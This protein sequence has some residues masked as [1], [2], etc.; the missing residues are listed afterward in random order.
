MAPSLSVEYRS[1]MFALTAICGLIDAACFLALGGV[2]AEL[3]TG[4]LLLLAFSLGTQTF[5]AAN[6]VAYMGAILPFCLGAFSAGLLTNGKHPLRA[7]M[8][9]Y[10]V[11]FIAVLAAT[12]LTVVLD[13]VP[14]GPLGVEPP[15]G[16]DSPAWQRLL[17]VA[18]LAFA[19]GIHNA[20]MRKHGMPDV[21]TNVMTL[22]LAGFVSESKLSRGTA[23]RWQQRIGSI[24][25]FVCSA[26]LGAYL[27]R[28]GTAAPLILATGLFALALWPLMKGSTG[29]QT[30]VRS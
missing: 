2:F 25:V 17:I 10:P 13:P 22:T 29:E 21:A 18:L 4:N 16:G 26:A 14:T 7:R 15:V 3:M 20:L 11:E 5:V 9:G 12:V 6:V 24:T 1:G 30:S 23:T 19:M 8:T 28:F 27:I